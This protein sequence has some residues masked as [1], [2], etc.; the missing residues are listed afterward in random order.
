MKN[1]PFLFL[2]LLIIY[3]ITNAYDGWWSKIPNGDYAYTGGKTRCQICHEYAA[4]TP[5]TNMLNGFGSD[6]KSAGS[7]WNQTLAQK[8]SD[9]DNFYNETELSCHNYNWIPSMGTC[10][11]DLTNIYNPGDGMIM[12]GPAVEKNVRVRVPDFL[13]ATPNPFNPGTTLRFSAG[14]PLPSGGRLS[15][16]SAQG[17]VIRTFRVSAQNQ[18]TGKVDWNGCA[19]NGRP[20]EA[21]IYT[22]ALELP[23]KRAK[24]LLGRG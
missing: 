19:E 22:A 5:S 8:D 4:P 7:G 6:F 11:S 1:R 10:G 13:F 21:G 9:G 24:A 17:K 12:P 18:A 14:A 20:A 3:N 2:F 16:F 23:G 15:I